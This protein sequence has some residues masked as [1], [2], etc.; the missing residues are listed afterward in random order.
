[1]DKI[2]VTIIGAGIIGLA[3]AAELSEKYE[4][5]IIVEKNDNFGQETSSRNSEVI[6]AGIYYPEGSLKHR[7]CIDGLDYLYKLCETESIPHKSIGKII[8]AAKASELSNLEALFKKGCI[9]NVLGLKLLD[10]SDIKKLEPHTNAIAGI[11]SPRTGI[12][13]SH[14][15]MKYFARK[16]KSK[17]AEIVYRSEVNLIRKEEKGFVIGLKD[18]DYKFLSELVI[19]A[20]GLS[21][22]HIATLA[23][24]NIDKL[25]YK[26]H[27]CKGDYFAYSKP[28]PVNMLIYPLPSEDTVSLGVHA[29]I[30]MGSRLRFGPDAEYIG[31]EINYQVDPN[32]GELFY[33]AASMIIPGLKKEAIMPDMA[34]IRP[35][36][37]GP[38]DSFKDFIIKDESDNDLP[39]LINLIGIKSQA[40]PPAIPLPKKVSKIAT[41]FLN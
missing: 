5:I 33:N 22:D 14:S 39:G 4:D 20:A 11:Y 36:L 30:D 21:S 6:H 35:K 29:T 9:N 26:L 18:D 19:N 12:V 41:A 23:D 40:L 27:Y 24:L 34:G 17:G 2:T 28:S 3:I 1:M 13:D 10:G 8:I 31:N 7:L 32:K 37:Q 38:H 16:T 15:L 25:G